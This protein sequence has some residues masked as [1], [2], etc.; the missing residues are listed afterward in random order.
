MNPNYDFPEINGRN[1]EDTPKV[2]ISGKIELKH[3]MSS[4]YPANSGKVHHLFVV[5]INTKACVF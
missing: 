5:I 3:T 4:A 1:L 2:E